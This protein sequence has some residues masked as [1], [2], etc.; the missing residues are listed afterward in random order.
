MG[1]SIIFSEEAYLT[2]YA[3]LD[4]L[5]ENWGKP[6]TKKLLATIYQKINLISHHPFIYEQSAIDGLRKAAV[7]N[8]TSFYYLVGENQISIVFFFDNRQDPLL[9]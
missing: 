1:I 9:T 3:I 6:Y 7:S 4:F 2:L 5:E 8:Y